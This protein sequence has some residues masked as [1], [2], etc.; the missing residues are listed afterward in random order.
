M[1]IYRVEARYEDYGFTVFKHSPFFALKSDAKKFRHI[2]VTY[3]AHDLRRWCKKY[4]EPFDNKEIKVKEYIVFEDVAEMSEVVWRGDI[5]PECNTTISHEG[6]CVC[7]NATFREHYW[8][9]I[10]E[11]EVWHYIKVEEKKK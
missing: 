10:K 11:E 1:K 7:T 6:K 2:L 5:C 4:K 8:D 9:S 3:K